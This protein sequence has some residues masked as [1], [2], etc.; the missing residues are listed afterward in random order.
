LVNTWA[1]GE[2]AAGHRLPSRLHWP[3]MRA[4]HFSGAGSICP[5]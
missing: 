5:G 2:V 1:G 3:A 4:R